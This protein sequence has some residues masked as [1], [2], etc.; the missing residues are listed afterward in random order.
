MNWW[1]IF[2]FLFLQQLIKAKPEP[3][4][5]IQT[6]KIHQNKFYES[7]T[8]N[9]FFIRGIAYQKTRQEGE[10]YDT[11]KETNYIDPLSNPFT[12]LRDLENL[13]ELNINVVRIYQI[14]PLANHDVCMN[15]FASEG[16]YIIADLSEPFISIKRDSPHW[17]TEIFKRYKS[18]VDSMS[19]YNNVLGF[20]AGNEIANS[21]SNIDS[22]PFIRSSIRDIKKY[23]NDMGYRKIPIGYASNDDTV[24][25]SNL[26]N[27]LVCDLP[28]D[29]DNEL[30]KID[31]FAIN[32]YEWCGYSTYAT[33]GYKDLNLEFN[34]F[35]TPIFF[36]EFGCNLIQPR[37]FTEIE[38]IFNKN[39]K[40]IWS[41]GIMYEYFE[42]INHYGL[43]LIKKDQSILKLPDFENLKSKYNAI[44]DENPVQVD[45]NE[46]I[47]LNNVKCNDLISD[48]WNIATNLPQTPNSLKCDC[49]YNSLKCIILPNSQNSFDEEEFIKNLCYKI[50]CFEINCNGKIGQYG[51]YSDCSPLIRASFALNQYY[52]QTGEKEEICTLQNRGE[53]QN[54]SLS[55]DQE[56]ICFNLLNDEID[57]NEK[58]IKF[59]NEKDVKIEPN[60]SSNESLE[61]SEIIEPELLNPPP[62]NRKSKKKSIGNKLSPK[63]LISSIFH[64]C[65]LY[66]VLMR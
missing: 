63:R 11:T 29:E 40:K 62:I 45:L 53:L 52:L 57:S 16:I 58:T 61:S 64:V 18:V 8:K 22:A 12:C 30:S 43:I 20:F 24:I 44:D 55:K 65:I 28:N 36:S 2:P 23:I 49:L 66:F 19:K 17:D 35:P 42:E 15:A 32:N 6:I 14:N 33:S 37:P 5:L 21:Q 31:F 27:Y 56:D 26:A 41:G 4:Q 54:Q 7:T 59:H 51:K 39:M 46:Q 25:R 3:S 47:E 1:Y 38:S 10:I 60:K 50:D 13:V 48:T 34:K 9:Q